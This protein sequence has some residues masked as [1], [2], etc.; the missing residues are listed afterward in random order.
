MVVKYIPPTDQ[1]IYQLVLEGI[2]FELED[3]E[4][5]NGLDN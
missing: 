1:S 4:F 5:Y 2:E 3:G